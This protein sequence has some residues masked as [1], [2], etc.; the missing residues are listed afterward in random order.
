MRKIIDLHDAKGNFYDEYL[1]EGEWEDTGNYDEESEEFFQADHDCMPED[2]LSAL[3]D[4]T[5]PANHP[6]HMEISRGMILKDEY[7]SNIH[8]MVNASKEEDRKAWEAWKKR[9]TKCRK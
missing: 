6:A 7:E 3:D 8:E 1:G 4:I 2:D 9:S 5:V